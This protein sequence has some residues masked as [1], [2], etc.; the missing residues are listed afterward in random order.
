MVAFWVSPAWS[1]DYGNRSP[2]AI[3]CIIGSVTYDGATSSAVSDIMVKTKPFPGLAVDAEPSLRKPVR[4]LLKNSQDVL[5]IAQLG[6]WCKAH[7][8]FK[9]VQ[10]AAWEAGF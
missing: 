1:K 5:A 2:E 4:K 9:D 8:K 10:S 6:K 7:F 3:A